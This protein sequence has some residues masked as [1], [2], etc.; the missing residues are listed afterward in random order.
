MPV[1]VSVNFP[2]DKKPFCGGRLLHV[3]DE[4]ATLLSVWQVALGD[5][6]LSNYTL[7]ILTPET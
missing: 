7:R 3:D 2:G 1:A 4:E 6:E 5:N